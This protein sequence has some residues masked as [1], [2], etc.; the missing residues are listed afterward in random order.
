MEGLGRSACGGGDGGGGEEWGEVGQLGRARD[1][2]KHERLR[3]HN[4]GQ[5]AT[6]SPSAHIDE[7]LQLGRAKGGVDVHARCIVAS[8]LAAVVPTMLVQPLWINR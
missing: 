6:L 7:E 2:V 1:I 3:R 4:Q 8:G 5:A